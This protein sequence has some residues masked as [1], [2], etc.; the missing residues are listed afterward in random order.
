MSLFGSALQIF[1]HY[2]FAILFCCSYLYHHHISSTRLVRVRKRAT[3]RF[4]RMIACARINLRVFQIEL[5]IRHL[6]H[7][8]VQIK[9]AHIPTT[10]TPLQAIWNTAVPQT[11]AKPSDSLRLKQLVLILLYIYLSLSL[12]HFFFSLY[13]RFFNSHYSHVYKC[14]DSTSN[15]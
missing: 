2:L 1:F 9:L 3:H 8:I 6:S 11:E 10:T 7:V 15:P 14:H 4:I 12:T 13:T 5:P